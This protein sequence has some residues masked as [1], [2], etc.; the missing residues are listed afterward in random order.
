MNENE[1]PAPRPRLIVPRP[2]VRAQQFHAPQLA[3]VK[4]SSVTA[5]WWILIIG[6]IVAAIPGIGFSMLLVAFP[7]CLASFALGI[8]GASSGRPAGGVLLIVASII[9]FFL[10]L[11]IPWISAAIG[12]RMVEP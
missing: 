5:G 1:N 4:S 3:P 11:L 8:V 9:S 10:M 12:L 7:V 2:P 6:F